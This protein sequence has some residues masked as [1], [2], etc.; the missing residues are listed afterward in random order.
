MFN[1]F[2]RKPISIP[3]S[4]RSDKVMS[5]LERLIVRNRFKDWSVKFDREFNTYTIKVPFDLK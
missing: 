4:K 5:Q 1:W 2:K 3:M